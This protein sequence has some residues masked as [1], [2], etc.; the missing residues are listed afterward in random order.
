MVLNNPNYGKLNELSSEN[1]PEN[2]RFQGD[3]F[4]L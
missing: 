4:H 2:M 3:I 1:I